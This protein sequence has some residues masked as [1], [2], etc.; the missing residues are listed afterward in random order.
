MKVIITVLIT[1]GI[2]AALYVTV[3]SSISNRRAGEL[4]DGGDGI[5]HTIIKENEAKNARNGNFQEYLKE[6]L[7][8]WDRVD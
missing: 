3:V 6:D 7:G 2:I 8:K 1:F 4:R 5:T